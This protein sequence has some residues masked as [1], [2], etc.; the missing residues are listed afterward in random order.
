MMI[1]EYLAKIQSKILELKPNEYFHQSKRHNT[2]VQRSLLNLD[3]Q[4]RHKNFPHKS[5]IRSP[6]LI[7][8]V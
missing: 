1:Q 4:T 6:L 7:W 2:Y 8:R 3:M 5:V